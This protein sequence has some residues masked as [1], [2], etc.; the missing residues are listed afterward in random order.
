MNPLDPP[1]PQHSRWCRAPWILDW[2]IDWLIDWFH[3]IWSLWQAFFLKTATERYIFADVSAW[4][5]QLWNLSS[6]PMKIS[7][8]HGCNASI[9]NFKKNQPSNKSCCTSGH[10]QTWN[11]FFSAWKS[12]HDGGCQSKRSPESGERE[13]CFPPCY[14]SASDF[15]QGVMLRRWENFKPREWWFFRFRFIH[16][17]SIGEKFQVSKYKLLVMV[18]MGM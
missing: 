17:T 13:K 4:R 15:C 2:F 16:C 12:P 6:P 7:I 1:F 10:L 5:W 3:L 8:L 14:S 9:S 18:F 11:S